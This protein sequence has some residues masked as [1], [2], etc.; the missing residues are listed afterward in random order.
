MRIVRLL[1]LLLVLLG[2]PALGQGAAVDMLD[3]S[4]LA[5]LRPVTVGMFS[6]YDRTGLNDDGFSGAHSFL[7]K[8]GDGLVVAEV[9]G[10]GAI[11]R[12]W[13][14]TPIDAPIE[15]YFDGEKK[16]RLVLPFSALFSGTRAPFTGP[17]VGQGAGGYW[18]YVPITFPRSIKVVVRAPKLQ[19]YQIG[20]ARYPAGTRVRSYTAPEGASLRPA[21]GGR[22]T[23]SEVELMPGRAVTLFESGSAGR[24]TS[25]RLGPS[26]AFAGDARDIDIR[27]TWDGAAAPAVEMPVTELFGFSFGKPSAR[28]LLLGTEGEWS[29]FNFPMPY[30]RGAKIELV[31]RRNGG[32]PLRLRSEVTVSEQGRA[33]DEAYLHA[34]WSREVQV[35]KGQPFTMLDVT[36]R[37]HV[38]GFALQVQGAVPGDTGFF[39]GD[40]QVTIDGRLAIHGTG[41]EDMF[42]GGWYG[43]PGRWNDRASFPLSGALDYSRQLARTGGYRLLIGDAWSFA[44]SL[45]FTVEHGP[46]HNASDGDYAGTVFY[47]L[48]RPAGDPQRAAER[49][50]LK[51]KAF[52]IGTYPFAGIDTLIDASLTP[53]GKELPTGGVSIVTF[54]RARGAAETVFADTWGPPL[55]A[56]RVEAPQAGRY[57]IHLDALTG[58]KAAKLQLRD[59]NFAPVGTPTDFFSAEEKRTGFVSLGE[60]DLVEGANVVILTMPERNPASAGAEVAIIEIEGRLVETPAGGP[61]PSG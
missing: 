5:R 46:E 60:L 49:S 2:G 35:R 6:S 14:P 59:A 31:S 13:T 1:T 61:A 20:F 17:L 47:Y 48:D 39:E 41:T 34:R 12:I 21:E 38:A 15:F 18:S 22:R 40:E 16:P 9:E 19:F 58:P 28:S 10:P 37:G 54:A 45:R 25:L 44:K 52:R 23:A 24:I 53:G 4:Q 56:L 43:L 11:T 33:A 29:Y 26:A 36:G 30:S 8:E 51:A 57:A 50:V 3:V 42:N 7:R 32:G 55:V 27:M